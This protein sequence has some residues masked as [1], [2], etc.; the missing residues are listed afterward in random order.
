MLGYIAK[1]LLLIPPKL[2]VISLVVFVVLNLAGSP[3][4]ESSGDSTAKQGADKAWVAFRKQFDLD[5]PILL[6]TRYLTT[7]DQVATWLREAEAVPTSPEA[8]VAKAKAQQRLDDWGWELV[9]H[10]ISLLEGELAAAAA[11]RLT[12]A[13]QRPFVAEAAMPEE[14]RRRRND[15]IAAENLEVGRWLPPPGGTEAEVEELRSRWLGWWAANATEFERSAWDRA[16]MTFLDTR[17]ARYWGRLARLDLG[18]S[19]LTRR[20]VLDEIRNRIPTSVSLALLS[21]ALAYGLALPIGVYSAARPDTPADRFLTVVL[22][23]MFSM[24]TFFTGTV[25][26]RLLATGELRVFPSMGLVTPDTDHYT[27]V[28]R[29]FD[30]LWHL[31]LPVAT[32]ASVSLAALSRYARSGVIDVIRA[33]YVR[34]A[35]AKGLHEAVVIVKHAARNGMIPIL[36]LLGSLLATLFGGSVVIETVFG[37]PGMGSYLFESISNRDYQ[38]VMGILLF[39]SVLTL[40]GV[41]LSDLLYAL[42]DPRISYE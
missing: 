31:S 34:T 37:I 14:D 13:A 20:K 6:N 10:L 2:F 38:P 1:R 39:S 8:A 32:Y 22:F 25:L 21:L 16:R 23:L 12:V 33:D 4:Q 41:F 29:A 19:T 17:F 36:T 30:V 18:E 5:L 7:K 9:P 15:E 11:A 28:E 26:L 24:P 42:A 3:P 27:A 40:L 35:R